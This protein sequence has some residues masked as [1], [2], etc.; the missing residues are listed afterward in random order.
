M[1]KFILFSLLF[2]S[3]APIKID[4]KY[5]IEVIN[6]CKKECPRYNL[7]YRNKTTYFCECLS[8][9]GSSYVVLGNKG[10]VYR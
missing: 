3:C 8:E 1:I 5:P 9:S 6:A 4:I 2:V 7:I 10:T